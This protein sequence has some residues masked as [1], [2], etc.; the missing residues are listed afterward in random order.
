MMIIPNKVIEDLYIIFRKLS[1]QEQ[2][3]VG[4]I[5][6]NPPIEYPIIFKDN[7]KP[8]AYIYLSDQEFPFLYDNDDCGNIH[9]AIIPEYRNKGLTRKL[10]DALLKSTKLKHIIWTA[11]T[12]NKISKS[13]GEKFELIFQETSFDGKDT[14]NYYKVK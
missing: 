13:I 12:K 5:L 14:Y 10:I 3:F 11:N 7:G 6:E 9:I 1:E 4:D 2:Y 8:V